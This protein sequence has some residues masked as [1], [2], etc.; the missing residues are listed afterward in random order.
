MPIA[1]KKKPRARGTY[2]RVRVSHSAVEYV[3]VPA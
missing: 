2:P 3:N 1:D